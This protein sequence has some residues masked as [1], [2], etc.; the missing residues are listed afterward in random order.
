[1][2]IQH[3][4]IP[5]AGIHEPKGAS[6]A[7]IG[8]V[9]IADGAGSGAWTNAL[10]NPSE[11]RIERLLDA[12]SL[13]ASQEPSVVDTPLQL[14]VGAAQFTASDPVSL[15]A[16]GVVTFN[17]AGTYRVKVSLAVGRTGGAGI[18]E[19]YVRA[20]VNGVQAGQSIHFKIGSADSY[21]AFTDEAW[22][23]IPAGTTLCYEIMRDS[24][25]N[26]SGG[27]FAGLP[28]PVDW[29]DNPS[30]ALRVERWSA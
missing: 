29:A 19:I 16:L 1:M 25:G 5:N 4:D 30:A 3:T 15:D 27:A 28:T 20:M 24:S 2:T 17:Q 22:L 11:I 26:N 14:E 6:S 23:N 10:A 13:A 9:Y 12:L 7:L 8:Q 18:A 21:H